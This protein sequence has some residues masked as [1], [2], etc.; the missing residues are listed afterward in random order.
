MCQVGYALG[1]NGS[2]A[3][4]S[5]ACPAALCLNASRW[6]EINAF[7]AATGSRL[8]FGLSYDVVNGTQAEWDPSQVQAMLAYSAGRGFGRNILGFE[9]GE[10]CVTAA[11]N[12]PVV[13]SFPY[14]SRS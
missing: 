11:S 9:L 12:F 13:R 3:Y 6:D 8:V 14:S 1:N 4:N 5:S 10:E 7:A 2:Y